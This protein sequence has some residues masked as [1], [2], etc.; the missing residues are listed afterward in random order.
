MHPAHVAAHEKLTASACKQKADN[1][2]DSSSRKKLKQQR[3]TTS[4][5]TR[6]ASMVSQAAVDQAIVNLVV[7]A[8]LPLRIV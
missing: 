7:G 6:N 4:V 3:I 2:G 1:A 5:P 8:R